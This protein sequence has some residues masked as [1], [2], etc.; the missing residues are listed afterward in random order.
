MHSLDPVQTS[1]PPR[2]ETLSNR[3]FESEKRFILKPLRNHPRLLDIFEE[4]RQGSFQI[5][6]IF[7]VP[8]NGSMVIVSSRVVSSS[9]LFRRISSCTNVPVVHIFNVC[10]LDIFLSPV[11]TYFKCL[12]FTKFVNVVW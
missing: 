4:T 3:Y 7:E 5:D 10:H 11:Y 8:G 12:F 2:M 1:Q 6:H 9:L